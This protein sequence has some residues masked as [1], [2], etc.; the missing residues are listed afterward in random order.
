MENIEIPFELLTED[1][2]RGL[3][4]EFVSREG[5]DYGQGEYSLEAKAAAVR[6]QLEAG[7]AVI[8]YDPETESCNIVLKD[9][10]STR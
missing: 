1:A 4:E 3:I 10:L 9:E 8:V 7:R 6:R 5:T 2:L